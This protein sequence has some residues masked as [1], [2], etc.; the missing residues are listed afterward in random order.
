MT[1]LKRSELITELSELRKPVLP[2]EISNEEINEISVKLFQTLKEHNG[3]G[4]SANQIGIQKR[5]CVVNVD[6]PLILVNPQIVDASSDVV[7]YAEG[8]LSIPK[9]LKKSLL[10][11]RHHTVK[12]K[13]DNHPEVLEF[14]PTNLESLDVINDIG[15]LEAVCVQHEIDHL[16]GITIYERRLHK[17]RNVGAKIGRNEMVLV[18]NPE[19][20]ETAFVKYKKAQ[21]LLEMGWQMK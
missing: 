4:L 2:S 13:T 8:C 15:L 7:M 16:N 17:P 20:G 6:N 19:S 5:I 18:E 21:P 10:T 11:V 1:D 9:T 12:V 3:T 14:K